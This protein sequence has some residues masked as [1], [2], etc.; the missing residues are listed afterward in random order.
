VVVPK[1]GG[2]LDVSCAV[3]EPQAL[4]SAKL[5]KLIQSAKSLK[6]PTPLFGC[7][8]RSLQ[9]LTHKAIGPSAAHLGGVFDNKAFMHMGVYSSNLKKEA[10]IHPIGHSHLTQARPPRC[11][12]PQRL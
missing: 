4:K 11:K 1:E 6:S 7:S 10:R 8:L 2:A 5:A 3:P 9:V 12:N